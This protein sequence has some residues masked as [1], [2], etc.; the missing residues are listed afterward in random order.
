MPP[1]G[2]KPYEVVQESASLTL[3]GDETEVYRVTMLALVSSSDSPPANQE[4]A[5][6]HTDQ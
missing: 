6:P 4:T 5:Q 3:K 1:S 2:H